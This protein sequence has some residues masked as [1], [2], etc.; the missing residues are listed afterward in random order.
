MFLVSCLPNKRSNSGE[1]TVNNKQ[2]SMSGKDTIWL[3]PF[4]GFPGTST[5]QQLKYDWIISKMRFEISE[6]NN[7]F[8]P[9]L[10]NSVDI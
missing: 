6:K 9:N 5:C 7:I 1:F 2:G 3:T 8:I 10:L 4:E